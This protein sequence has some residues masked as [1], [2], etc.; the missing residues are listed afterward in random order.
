MSD[1]TIRKN[2]PF[3]LITLGE[4]L[5][6]ED[7]MKL[8][9]PNAK[10]PFDPQEWA[11][12]WLNEPDDASFYILDE[13]GQ[14][15]G[16][17]ALRVGVGPEVRHLTYVFVAP[18]ARGGAGAQMAALVE[19]AA[20]QLEALTLTLKVETDN[21]PAHNAYLSAGYEELSRRNGMATMRRDL[22]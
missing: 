1:L 2:A 8:V 19:Q 6:D 5:T 16:F 20:R 17:F 10:F 13:T 22:G 7:E 4:M 12:K 15:V 14:P 21:E 9:N 18:E 3:E 11:E